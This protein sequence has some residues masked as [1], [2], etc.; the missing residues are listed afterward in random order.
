MTAYIQK[1]NSYFSANSAKTKIVACFVLINI[2]LICVPALSYVRAFGQVEAIGF[3]WETYIELKGDQLTSRV[4][5]SDLDVDELGIQ[6]IDYS[7]DYDAS[8]SNKNTYLSVGNQ[9]SPI[10]RLSRAYYLDEQCSLVFS[11]R[12]EMTL[13]NV[14]LRCFY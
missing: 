8:N 12:A 9:I 3:K 13:K 7:Y 5:Y 11:G 2:F 1:I 10:I 6:V 14:S 4:T